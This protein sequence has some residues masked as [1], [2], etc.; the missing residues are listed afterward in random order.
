M[1]IQ[2]WVKLLLGKDAD[3]HL[4][5]YFTLY[6]EAIQPS[7][8]ANL[9]SSKTWLTI[10]AYIL[11]L[12]PSS[13]F[14]S[15]FLRKWAPTSSNTE[16][17]PNAGQWIGYI[18]RVLILTFILIGC[19]EGIGFLLAAK[20]V[21]RFGEMSKAKDIR[22]TEYMLI[23]TFASFAIATLTGVAVLHLY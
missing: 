5:L 2:R 1:L 7:Y 3:N 4:I 8:F 19:F 22:S 13:I 21:F 12:R 9:C 18:E 20:S 14:L 10:T 17:L 23:G 11:M 6:G 16:S 15:L